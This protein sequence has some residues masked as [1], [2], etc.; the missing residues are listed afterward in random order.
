MLLQ[1]QALPIRAAAAAA[2]V[3]IML[4]RVLPVVQV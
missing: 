3:M 4:L 1:L 2:A